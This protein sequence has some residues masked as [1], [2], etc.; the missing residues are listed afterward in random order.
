MHNNVAYGK[1]SLGF[2]DIDTHFLITSLIFWITC[3]IREN[4][5]SEM[6]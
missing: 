5:G 6:C 3:L 2:V 1:G 4:M